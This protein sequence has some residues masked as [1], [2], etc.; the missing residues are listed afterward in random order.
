MFGPAVG[1]LAVGVVFAAAALWSG[2]AAQALL[3]ALPLFLVFGYLFGTGPAVMAG[4]AYAMAPAPLQRIALGPF[5]GIFSV[6]LFYLLFGRVIGAPQEFGSSVLVIGAGAVAATAC[7][8]IVRV[9][10]LES[11]RQPEG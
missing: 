4:L 1:G 5:Y 7:A 3:G 10:R 11:V 2:G 9:S 6:V 8:A